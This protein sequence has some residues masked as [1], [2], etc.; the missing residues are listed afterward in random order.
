LIKS[1]HN[2]GYWETTGHGTGANTSGRVLS[3]CWAALQLEVYY[4]YLPS[5]DS[6]KFETITEDDLIIEL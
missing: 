4:R 2:E 1:Q 5:F 6:S 3:T